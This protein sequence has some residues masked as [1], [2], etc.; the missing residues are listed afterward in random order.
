MPSDQFHRV[1]KL[2]GEC[3]QWQDATLENSWANYGA[4]NEPASY[5]KDPFNVVHLRGHVDSGTLNATIFTLPAGYRPSVTVLR[6]CHE[7]ATSAVRLRI[8]TDGTVKTVG[9]SV[10]TGQTIEGSFRV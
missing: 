2:V 5:Y 4:S 7:S 6:V 10:N 9:A 1:E 8:G 3:E